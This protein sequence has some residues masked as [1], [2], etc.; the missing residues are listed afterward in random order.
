M[1]FDPDLKECMLLIKLS[2][3]SI[4]MKEAASE[5]FKE[6]KFAE[7]IESFEE[8]LKLDDLNAAYNSTLLLNIAIAHNKLDKKEEAIRALTRAVKYNPKYAKAY[9]KRGEMYVDIGEFDEAI[10]DFSTASEY[11]S[12]GF[13]VVA[14]MKD[15]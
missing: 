2:K 10:R 5:I 6:G 14:K 1:A 3:K 7:A 11:D 4:S 15:A 13:G 12:T 8:C 9:V